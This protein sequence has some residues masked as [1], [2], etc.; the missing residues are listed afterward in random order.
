MSFRNLDLEESPYSST[1]KD[2]PISPRPSA[3]TERLRA[4]LV[5]PSEAIGLEGIT[6]EHLGEPSDGLKELVNYLDQRA[7]MEADDDASEFSD[8]VEI[9]PN[10]DE[11]WE[12]I[13]LTNDDVPAS[14]A[15]QVGHM[16]GRISSLVD[17]ST[18]A[19][20]MVLLSALM[21]HLMMGFTLLPEDDDE[22]D[23]E[24]IE[25]Q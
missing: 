7:E 8:F 20:V 15:A 9:D 10:S 6:F 12:E 11:L 18:I 13:N 24:A 1:I 16:I 22:D 14:R 3:L 19:K 5:Q 21:V 25:L 23:E 4:R 2:G 17:G